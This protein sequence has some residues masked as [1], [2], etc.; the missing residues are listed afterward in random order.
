MCFLLE[1]NATCTRFVQKSRA[2]AAP[3]AFKEKINLLGGAFVEKEKMCRLGRDVIYLIKQALHEAAPDPKIL[4][5]T[6]FPDLYK[7][8]RFHSVEAC[9]Y[10]PLKKALE[11]PNSELSSKIDTNIYKRIENSYK[12]SVRRVIAY[13]VEREALCS[14]F[15]KNGIWYLKM[16]GIVLQEYYPKLGMRQMADNDILFDQKKARILRDFMQARGYET[17]SYG[18]GCHDIYRKGDLIFEMHRSLIP[19][20]KENKQIKRG[21]L[22]I[23]EQTA[24]ESAALEQRFSK[25]HFYIYF[26]IHTYKHFS[27]AGCGIRPLADV[28]V[29]TKKHAADL[30]F[31][32]VQNFLSRIGL[33][34]FEEKL[35]SLSHKLFEN[36]EESVEQAFL[37]LTD[38]EREMLSYLITSGTFGTEKRQMEN[39]LQRLSKTKSPGFRAKFKYILERAF[40]P[41]SFYRSAYPRLSRLIVPIP[42]LWAGRLL[43]AIPK[44]ARISDEIK[45]LKDMGA[46]DQNKE[47][48]Y[49]EKD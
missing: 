26:L 47:Q 36:G 24:K 1:Y 14:F 2:Q 10:L 48:T 8:A 41:F 13:D 23:L 25:E 15:E 30:D 28:Y 31:A 39:D 12:N 34:D 9:I 49:V 38:E 45:R 40:P 22:E 11:Q 16:K 7:M 32:Y 3:L 5:E 27:V 42:F 21:L 43:S 4:I 46:T 18:R 29:Y 33:A 20:K 17:L 37:R 35:K 6:D 19:E 44:R